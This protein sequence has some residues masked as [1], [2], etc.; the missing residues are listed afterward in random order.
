MP[1]MSESQGGD[2]LGEWRAAMGAVVSAITSAGRS[3]A[4]RPLLGPLQ[5]QAELIER[6]L[7]QQRQIQGQLVDRAFE[8]VDAIFDLLER[9]GAMMRAQA[10]ALEQAAAAVEQAAGLMR[11]QAELFETA[12]K[13]ARAPADLVQR[14]AGGT[15]RRTRE[16]R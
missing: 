7:E 14:A 6:V 4:L 9:S 15:R 11:T 3:E 5:H 12:T 8:P 2:L 10:E 16:K 1:S 13:T